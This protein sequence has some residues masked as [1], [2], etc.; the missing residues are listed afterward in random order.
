ML[1][2]WSL[3]PLATSISEMLLAE[4]KSH[5][6]DNMQVRFDVKYEEIL[7]ESSEIFKPFSD[8]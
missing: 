5:L 3:F 7:M 4:K 6:S 1:W 2:L 8:N